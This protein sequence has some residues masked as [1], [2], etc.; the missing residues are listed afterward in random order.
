MD[1]RIHALLIADDLLGGEPVGD[2]VL[3]RIR[4][5]RSMNYIA[6]NINA[7]IT[8]DGARERIIGIGGSDESATSL[9][10]IATCQRTSQKEKKNKQQQQQQNKT[11]RKKEKRTKINNEIRNK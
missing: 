11:K 10:D 8:T 1:P 2:L 9:D 5:I 6:T 7:E 3:G 4:S